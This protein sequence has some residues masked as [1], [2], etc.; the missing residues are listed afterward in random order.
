M[1][2]FTVL[3]ALCQRHGG[4]PPKS[5]VTSYLIP[6]HGSMAAWQHAVAGYR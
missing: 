3:S 1:Y 5:P 4:V 6:V 2:I